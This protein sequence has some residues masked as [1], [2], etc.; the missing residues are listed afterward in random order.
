MPLPTP[1]ATESEGDFI[2]RCLIDTTMRDEFPA[3]DQRRQVCQQRWDNKSV[4]SPMNDGATPGK[5][6]GEGDFMERCLINPG[7]L[8]MFPD[9]DVR[10][11]ECQGRWDNARHGVA[12]PK[13]YAQSE[14]LSFKFDL[15]TLGES[16]FEGYGSTFGNVDL[17][18]D[19]VLPGAF[20][21]SLKQ[22]KNRGELPQMFYM[23]DPRLVPGVWLDMKEDSNGLYVKGKL[24]M[25]T[26]LGRETHA[27]LK[28]KALRGMSIGYGVENRQKDVA[29]DDEGN[30]LLK[31][32]DLVEVSIVS[33]PM[34]IEAKVESVKALKRRYE[35]TIR[36]ECNLGSLAAKKATS[37]FFRILAPHVDFKLTDPGIRDVDLSRDANVDETAA[38]L[39]S[40]EGFTDSLRASLFTRKPNR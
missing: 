33:M 5:N 9:Y 11:S 25:D 37:V 22:Q 36:R 21:D 23:H 38:A 12:A 32:L 2:D 7:M 34:N 16:E 35:Q 19:I 28:A 17:G 30:R 40:I 24:L 29:W 27:Q 3:R 15:K 6:E 8:D 10:A 26:Q 18:G 20:K 1:T 39:E 13:G 4:K 31:K 14:S